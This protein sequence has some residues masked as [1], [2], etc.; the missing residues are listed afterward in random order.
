MLRMLEVLEVL[1]VICCVLLNMLE[2]MEGELRLPAMPEVP[3]L[4]QCV[5]LDK[6]EAVG[7]GLWAHFQ[8]FGV[9]IPLRQFSH[10]SPPSSDLSMHPRKHQCIHSQHLVSYRFLWHFYCKNL[11]FLLYER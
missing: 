8:G 1:G 11:L 9:S 4:M 10:Y 3:V 7:G 6:M 5:L 2:A